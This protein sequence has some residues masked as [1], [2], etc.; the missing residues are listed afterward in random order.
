MKCEGK[1]KRSGHRETFAK[2][3]TIASV[4]SERWF[5]VM[6]TSDGKGAGSLIADLLRDWAGW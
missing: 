1:G 4:G 5:G 2:G 6:L 3:I